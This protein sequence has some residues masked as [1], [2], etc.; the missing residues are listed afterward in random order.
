MEAAKLARIEEYVLAFFHKRGTHKL[1][2]REV[3]DGA[4]EFTNADLVRAFEALEK[5]Q[6]LLARY[7]KEG[8]DWLHLTPE[9]AKLAGLPEAQSVAPPDALPHP[10]RSST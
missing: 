2:T 4:A 8:E 3:F 9:G 5:Q 1:L 10:P 7:T 6:R